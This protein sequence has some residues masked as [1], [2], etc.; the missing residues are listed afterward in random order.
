MLH[1][2]TISEYYKQGKPLPIIDVRSP[3]EYE[4]GHIPGAYNVPLFTNEERARVGTVYKRQSRELAVELGTTLVAP[5]LQFYISESFKIAPD[6]RALVHCW[7]GGMRSQAFA[8]H[9][10]DNGFKEIWLLKNGY[11]S[12]R[13]MVIKLFQKPWNLVVIGGYTGSGKTH[14]LHQLNDMGH[15]VIDW[16]GVARHKGSAFGGIGQLQQPTSEQFENNLFEECW[17]MDATQPVFIEDESLNI[18]KVNMPVPLFQQ[19]RNSIDYFLEVPREERAKLLSSEYSF[20]NVEPLKAAVLRIS[21]KLG[22]LE[23]KEIIELLEER[24]FYEV[25]LRVLHYYDKSYLKGLQNRDSSKT[26]IIPCSSTNTSENV[27]RI[28]AQLQSSH[29]SLKIKAIF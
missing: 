3:G 17:Q 12:Y 23:T 20:Q 9:L 26:V 10:L 2:T 24:K 7:R 1:V 15:Q 4:K 8:Q 16:E 22:G 29:T 27:E 6:G 21:K 19:I 25:A 18:G 14:V 13:R 11:K 5:K 28:I